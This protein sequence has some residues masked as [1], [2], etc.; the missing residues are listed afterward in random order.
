M[1]KINKEPAVT[2]LQQAVH[3]HRGV[4]G[5]LSSRIQQLETQEK[6]Y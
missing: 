6:D 3:N 2:M 1:D 4:I 5:N